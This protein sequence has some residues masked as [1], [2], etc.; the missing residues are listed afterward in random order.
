MNLKI[1]NNVSEANL[2]THDAKF[3]PDDVFSTVFMSKIVENPVVY[4]TSVRNVPKTDAIIYDVGFGKFDHHG[5]DSKCDE[6]GM[7][8]CS[9]GLLWEEYGLNYLKSINAIKPETLFTRIKETL[10]KQINGIDNGIFPTIEAPYKLLDLDKIIDLYNNTW[11]EKTDNNDNF[12]KAVKTANDI[13][14]LVIKREQSLLKADELVEQD[15]NNVKDNILILRNYM[16][17]SDTIF[18]SSNPKAKEIKIIITPSN[19]GGYDIKPITISKDSKELLIRFPSSYNGKQ[20][21]ELRKLSGIKTIM[22]VHANGFLANTGTL[23]D[24]IELAK[25]AINN[26]ENN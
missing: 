4:R 16:P 9:F 7:K 14:E 15:I 24:A 10:I 23:E 22:F 20:V 21:D 11:D 12:M 25:Q 19:R 26:P 8:Y 18:S 5:A 2:V 3:H 13:F 6:N 17:Y 1:T